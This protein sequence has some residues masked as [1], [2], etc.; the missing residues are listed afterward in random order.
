MLD[1]I[2]DEKA[3]ATSIVRYAPDSVF[4]RHAHP[5][6]E[7]ILVLSGTFSDE[8]GD[9]PAGW[10]VRN[11]PAS[12]HRPSS[13][14]GA[15]IF[16]KLW[17]MASDD[18]HHVHIDTRDPSAWQ[19]HGDRM[20]CPLFSSPAE[21]V[22]LQRLEAGQRILTGAAGGAE[23]LVLEGEIVT[24]NH[25]YARGTWIRLPAGEHPG[26]VAGERGVCF[27]LKTGHLANQE[28][29]SPGS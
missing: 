28:L 2:G 9:F 18:D 20:V 11:P 27:Y 8:S 5:G 4:P 16:V 3:R 26:F 17:Q 23:L 22:C 21:Q 29:P 7:E 24:G 15:L 19:R 14:E 6:G 25:A 13:R 10:Y 12:S 1:R